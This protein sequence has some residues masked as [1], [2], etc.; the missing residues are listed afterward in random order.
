MKKFEEES[1]DEIVDQLA[2]ILSDPDH[3]FDKQNVARYEDEPFWGHELLLCGIKEVKGKPIDKE[4]IYW[5][6]CPVLRIQDHRSKMHIAYFKEGRLGVMRYLERWM[7]P[8]DLEF[9][10]AIVMGNYSGYMERLNQKA[11]A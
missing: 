1:I 4:Q 10:R 6:P 11:S 8:D 9:C 7:K 2:P 5:I 3:M